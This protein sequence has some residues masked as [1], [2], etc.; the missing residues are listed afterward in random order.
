MKRSE[1]WWINLNP[2]VGQEIQ[3]TRPCVIVNN[4]AV[5]ILPLRVVVPLTDWKERYNSADWMIKI[6]VDNQNLLTKTSAADCFQVR[7]VSTN[8]FLHTEGGRITDKDMKLIEKALAI[9]LK[10]E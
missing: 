6:E 9:V 3:K 4:D 8:R 2:T 1:I 7:S 10:I 5:G